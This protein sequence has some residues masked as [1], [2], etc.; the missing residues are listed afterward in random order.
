VPHN[1]VQAI[2][3]LVGGNYLE[4]NLRVLAQK[5]RIVVV[6]LTAGA[7]AQFNMGVL[8]RK[9]ATIVGTTLRA[10]PIEEKIALARE[11]ADRMVPQFEAGKLKPIVDTV[12]GFDHIAD[13][14]RLMESNAT[15]GKL[16][17]VWK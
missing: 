2:L 1:G 9:R 5:G 12:F 3:D 6:G 10:R 14:H 13:A 17:L 7:T 11:F 4:G 16:V 8:L 15:V